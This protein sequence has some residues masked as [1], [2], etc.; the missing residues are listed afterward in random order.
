MAE[1]SDTHC[2]ASVCSGIDA[3]ALERASILLAC[4]LGAYGSLILNCEG[5]G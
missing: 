2:R 4:A 3:S 1:V 5:T